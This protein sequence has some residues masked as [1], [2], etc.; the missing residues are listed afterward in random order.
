[1]LCVSFNN[2]RSECVLQ[3]N[4]LSNVKPINLV[5]FVV[6]TISKSWCISISKLFELLIFFNLVETAGLISGFTYLQYCI[7]WDFIS[8]KNLFL[9]HLCRENGLW[10][11][12]KLHSEGFHYLYYSPHYSSQINKHQIVGAGRL[13]EDH[14]KFMQLL[15][16][17]D[18]RK[19]SLG[20]LTCEWQDIIKL[21][22]WERGWI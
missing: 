2:V 10:W 19:W 5:L 20:K 21:I 14:E 1:M 22:L 12:R 15:V 3:F 6:F 16:Q 13:C 4:V 17:E 18:G 8:D 11:Y 7:H 9:R